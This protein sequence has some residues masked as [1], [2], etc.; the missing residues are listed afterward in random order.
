[1]DNKQKKQ[2]YKKIEDKSLWFCPLPFSHVFSSLS[3]RYAPCYD[4][5]QLYFDKNGERIRGIGHHVNNTSPREWYESEFMNRLRGEMLREDFN[6]EYLSR[7]CEGCWKQ[8]EKYGKS[9][10]MKYVDQILSDKFD[11]KVPELLRTVQEFI[12]YEKIDLKERILDIK[13]KIFGNACNLDCYMC[14]PRSASTRTAS[15]KKL[16]KIYDPDLDPSDGEK[17]NTLKY[18]DDAYLD[19]IAEIAP[20]IRSIKIIGGEPLVMKNHYKLLEKLSITGYSEGINLIYKTNLS[21]FDMEGYNF[22]NYFDSFREFVM[23][24]SI[25]TYGKYNDYIRKKS[26]WDDLIHNLQIMRNRKNARVNV[27]SVISMLTVLTYDK[28]KK[29]LTENN[30]DHTYYILEHPKI[31]HVKHLPY[32]IKQK[33]IVKYEGYQNIQNALKQEGDQ[34]TFVT[35]IEYCLALDKNHGHNLFEL[36]PEL[37]SYYYEAKAEIEENKHENI[38]R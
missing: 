5:H 10:R 30:I 35:A 20:Y 7:V 6:K 14:T 18:D 31:L 34:K 11:N 24:V 12:D 36:H 2:F 25:D 38:L 1:M 28:L 9:D 17:M 16:D 4:S 15:L 22:K 29:Y 26:D 19:Q 33:L 23:K 8:E 27:H 21:V 37:E 13:L 3:G 32:S